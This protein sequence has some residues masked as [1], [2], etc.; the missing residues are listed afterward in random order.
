MI[1][2]EDVIYAIMADPV[3][4]EI[5]VH[6]FDEDLRDFFSIA[7]NTKIKAKNIY[8]V[9]IDSESNLYLI[10]HEPDSGIIHQLVLYNL[11]TN[12]H[13]TIKLPDGWIEEI[14]LDSSDILY[15]VAYSN[16]DNKIYKYIDDSLQWQATYNTQIPG[17]IEDLTHLF[18]SEDNQLWLS[19]AL[20]YPKA[21][22][23]PDKRI[24]IRSPIFINP[25]ADIRNP[26]TWESPEPQAITEDGRAWFKSKRGL[27]WFQ[28]ETSEWCMFTTA[29]SN[30]V[31]DSDGNLWLV[32]DNAL[33]MLPASE[34]RA[35]DQW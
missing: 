15:F 23:T 24:I 33:Y 21:G 32:Y 14:E 22:Y 16:G 35:K 30:V 34:T 1:K 12:A 28:P 11:V 10:I 9:E 3:T 27:A 17:A 18:I 7:Q 26:V 13:W 20:W 29:K 8:D 25:D 5:S 19:D 31:K 6:Q 2:K 4:R